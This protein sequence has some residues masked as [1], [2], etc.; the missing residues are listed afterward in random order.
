[1]RLLLGQLVYTSFPGI[2]FQTIAGEQVPKEIQQAFM[3]HVV[4][5]H[6]DS[7]KQQNSEFRAVYL[8]QVT[9]EQTLFGWLYDD[10]TDDFG[11]SNVP[12]FI[13]YYIAEPLSAFQ[14]EIIY[15]FLHKGPVE[16]IDRH[17][18]CTSLETIVLPDLWGYQP[19]RPGVAI[20]LDVRTRSYTALKQGKLLDLFIS[21]DKQEMVIQLNEQVQPQDLV[22]EEST[23]HSLLLYKN[24]LFLIGVGI[25]AVTT[26]ALAVSIPGFLQTATL[27]PSHPEGIPAEIS[28]VFYKTL[29]EVPN[30]PQ[31]LFNYGGST[32]FVPLR[33]TTVISAIS[34]AQPQFQLRL[35]EPIESESSSSAGIK[36][37][38]AGELSFVQ[39][40]Q[41]VDDAQF[42]EAKERGFTLEQVPI[43]IEAI[44][45]YVNPRVSIPGL[46]LSQLKDI[47]TGKITNWQEVGGP[48][49]QITPFGS[50][51]QSSNLMDIFN[52]KLLLKE[53]GANV[54][55]VRNTTQSIYKVATTAGGIGYGTASEVV[56]QKNVHPLPL[57]RGAGE[58][59]ISPWVSGDETAFINSSYPLSRKLF[60][61]IKRDGTLDE[62]A[63]IAYANLLL[64]DE[65]QQLVA[66][67]G[68]VPI[69]L[70]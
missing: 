4:F 24:F 59:F 15:T 64:T 37:L 10:G 7:Y 36:T 38:L 31:G 63:G 14:L 65:G 49:L 58:A 20:P 17:S 42:F 33:S 2:G 68:F 5:Q 67:A 41:P 44:A 18:L 48:D 66:R 54:Q 60:V 46:S 32:L 45:F 69:R 13:C 51:Q 53:N 8:H 1:M 50:S 40:S 56:G 52:D 70:P 61:I 22:A 25:G 21:V 26:L 29:A 43:G 55:E 28:S 6:W 12:Y 35:V 16:L 47:F 27:V 34:R 62:Q 19:A 39:S 11:R 23:Y 3:Q 9:P 57:S 30:V